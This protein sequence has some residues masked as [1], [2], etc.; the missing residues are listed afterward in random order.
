MVLFLLIF[1][2]YLAGSIPVGLILSKIKG[3]DP[4]KAGSGNI[5][6]TNVLRTAG[7]VLGILTLLGDALKGLLPVL[8]VARYGE[9][10]IVV[11]AVAFAAFFGH[12]FPLFL[13]FKGGKG[14]AIA[15]GIYLAISPPAVLICAAVFVL[16]ILKWRYVSLGSLVAVGLIPFTL[17]LL[18]A[19]GEFVC[20]AFVIAAL[21]YLKH[22]ENIK[23]LL[24][25]KENKL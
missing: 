25:G 7:K 21:V 3:K 5:G 6:A 23:R 8:V 2:A 20:L 16:V 12:L 24:S 1:G 10:H 19:P 17:L 14:V 4:R 18:G 9:P 11:A 13:G 22:T 15:L